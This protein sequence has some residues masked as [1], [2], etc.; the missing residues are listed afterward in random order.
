[1]ENYCNMLDTFDYLI[2]CKIFEFYAKICM[3]IVFPEM[4]IFEIKNIAKSAYTGI[5]CDR[6]HKSPI[7]SKY[8]Q[9]ATSD[10]TFTVQPFQE[11]R[12]FSQCKT[13]RFLS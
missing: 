9:M 5:N 10:K 13:K 8:L 7:S 2:F 4:R 6:I 11:P 12:I 1:M 3:F